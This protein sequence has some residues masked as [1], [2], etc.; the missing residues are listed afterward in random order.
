MVSGPPTLESMVYWPAARSLSMRDASW[1]LL[2]ARYSISILKLF[3]KASG[4]LVRAS[5]AGGPLT[6]TLPS[7]WAAE[8]SWSHAADA[9][10]TVG[11]AAGAAAGDEV[12]PHAPR[13]TPS[14]PSPAAEPSR[15]TSRR[16]T[17]CV[18]I[19]DVPLSGYGAQSV[20]SLVS[21]C[22]LTEAPA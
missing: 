2:P 10:A 22:R 6:T 1:L 17:M 8:T 4:S 19:S 13:A 15:S 11:A 20:A 18:F 12:G 5:G 14:K 21:T 9:P 16:L 3:L 7:F